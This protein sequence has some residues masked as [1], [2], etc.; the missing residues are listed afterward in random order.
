[1]V[2]KGKIRKGQFGLQTPEQIFQSNFAFNGSNI[3]SVT[4]ALNPNSLTGLTYNFANDPAI[5]QQLDS[6][7]AAFDLLATANNT[8]QM[9]CRFIIIKVFPFQNMTVNNFI[10]FAD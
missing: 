10:L 2:T 3:G 6:N 4:G 1:M 9:F 5:T 8:I 7:N